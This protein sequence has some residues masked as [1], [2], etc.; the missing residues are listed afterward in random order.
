MNLRIGLISDTHGL[1][2][3]EAL[4][5]LAGCDWLLH[6]ASVD[7]I[8]DRQQAAQQLASMRDFREELDLR[9]NLVAAL[10]H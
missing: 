3:P 7:E 5:A 10:R 8:R 9:G 6:A 4:A 1:V 2:R